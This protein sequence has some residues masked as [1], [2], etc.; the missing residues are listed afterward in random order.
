MTLISSELLVDLAS[1]AVV[2][3][4]PSE[5]VREHLN[6]LPAPAGTLY[7]V[8]LGKAAVGMAATVFEAAQAQTKVRGIVVTRVGH[9]EDL[10]FT[11]DADFI[12]IEAGHPVPNGESVKAA[13]ACLELL[14]DTKSDDHVL[15]LISGGASALV[16]KAPAGSTAEDKQDLVKQLL[17]S[18]ADITEMNQIR[19]VFSQVK[20]GRL[21]AQAMP[22]P[23]TS[24]LIS[25]VVG[26]EPAMIGSGPSVQGTSCGRKALKIIDRFNIEISGAARS[27]LAHATLPDLPEATVKVIASGNVALKKLEAGLQAQGYK[28]EN[29]GDGL[30]GEA[31]DIGAAHARL[32]MTR[33]QALANGEKL[34]IISGGEL[35]V[36]IRDKDGKGGPNLEYLAGL[37]IGCEGM[38]KITA[39]A[40]DTDGIDGK[41]DHAG[42][43]INADSLNRLREKGVS[44]KDLLSQNNSYEIFEALDDLIKTGPTGTNVND[45]RVILLEK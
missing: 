25:D 3:C 5:A 21:A 43:V 45:L 2:S 26:D 19:S 31:R 16:S 22:A 6:D 1:W 20:G 41:G 7:I 44:P 38:E 18:G 9:G 32:A 4:L 29:L 8:S 35:T 17:A 42:A 14:K 27:F 36:T 15:F 28:V 10:S 30:T 37:M 23:V 11:E 33:Q 39:L 24:W 40:L 13:D 12:V 34:A